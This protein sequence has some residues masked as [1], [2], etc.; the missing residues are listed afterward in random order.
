MI[1][2]TGNPLSTNHV[3]KIVSRPFPR[4]YMTKAGKERKEE[5]AWEARSQWK[6]K[7]MTEDIAIAIKLFF[8]DKRR[9]DIDNYHKLSLDSLTG[10]VWVDDV[11]IRRAEIEKFYDKENPRIEL[12]IISKYS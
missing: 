8:G 11:Q 10:I 7:P 12:E 9:R 3:W 6:E 1:T 5:Y 4:N 2:L